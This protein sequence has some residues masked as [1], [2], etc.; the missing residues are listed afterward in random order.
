[1]KK[2]TKSTVIISVLSILGKQVRDNSGSYS[3]CRPEQHNSPFP[4]LGA[5]PTARCLPTTSTRNKSANRNSIVTVVSNEAPFRMPLFD[6]G[7]G[8][9][10][11]LW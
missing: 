1:M 4:T 5:S 7:V 9:D 6:F 2:K 10:T 8:L 3:Y 11:T